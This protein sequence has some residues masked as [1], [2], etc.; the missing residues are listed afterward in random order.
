MNGQCPGCDWCYTRTVPGFVDEDEMSDF[1]ERHQH[2]DF[3][4]AP[5]RVPK[6]LGPMTRQAIAESKARLRSGKK[7]RV[8]GRRR[9]PFRSILPSRRC[10][11]YFEWI[12]ENDLVT[13]SHGLVV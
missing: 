11:E 12:V 1:F 10:S 3:P 13:G 7:R 2:V 9:L 5:K 4:A 8:G 6:K